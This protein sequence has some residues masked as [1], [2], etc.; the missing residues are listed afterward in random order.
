MIAIGIGLH[1]LGEGLAIG[2]AY[3]VGELAA[4]ER[5]WSSGS[6]CTTPPRGWPSSRRWPASARRIGV[7]LGLGVVAGAPAILGAVIGAAV[8][9]AALSA[10][11]LGVGV[12]AI[13]QVIIQIRARSGVGTAGCSNPPSSPASPAGWR[14]CTSPVCSSP[15]SSHPVGTTADSLYL[16]ERLGV[17][18][19]CDANARHRRVVRPTSRRHTAPISRARAR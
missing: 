13:V 2:S 17:P 3:A 10:V 14:S 9:N 18:E 7:L 6:P 16:H 5:P 19:P 1:N 8:N 12:G 4:R 15:D 11:L